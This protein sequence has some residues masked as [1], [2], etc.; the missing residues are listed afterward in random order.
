M[1]KITSRDFDDLIEIRD[2]KK[3]E[4]WV[5]YP[6]IEWHGGTCPVAMSAKVEYV[7]RSKLESI[8]KAGDLSWEHFNDSSD[9]V[10]YRIDMAD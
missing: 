1:L 5:E 6:W 7:L 4:C 3:E 2:L 8:A 10:R 9:I